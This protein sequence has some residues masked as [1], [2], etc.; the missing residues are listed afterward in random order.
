MFSFFGPTY[1]ASLATPHTDEGGGLPILP[2]PETSPYLD[3]KPHGG[4]GGVGDSGRLAGAGRRAPRK[5]VQA[6][7]VQDAGPGDGLVGGDRP[8]AGLLQ[9]HRGVTTE[10]HGGMLWYMLLLT[11]LLVGGGALLLFAVI[12]IVAVVGGGGGGACIVHTLVLFV[13]TRQW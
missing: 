8:P 11:L 6:R 12:A 13:D 4:G 1:R 3:P 7:A 10:W 9:G 2:R 5:V